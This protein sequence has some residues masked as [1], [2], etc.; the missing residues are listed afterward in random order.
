MLA[1]QQLFNAMATA[2]EALPQHPYLYRPGRI[3]GHEWLNQSTI[4]RRE[5]GG[6]MKILLLL[7]SMA[8]ALGPPGHAQ[9]ESRSAQRAGSPSALVINAFECHEHGHA[10]GHFLDI[11]LKFGSA[12]TILVRFRI[13]EALTMQTWQMQAAKARFSDVVKRAADSGPQEITVHG[14][15][16]AVVVSRELFDQLSGNGE[17]LVNFMRSSPCADQDDIEFERDRSL[18]REVEF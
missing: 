9:G 6:M 7:R 10:V 13:L 15:A 16:V 12:L 1:A 11:G 2:T 17:S 14:R 8:G 3:P 5:A 4:R 18:P